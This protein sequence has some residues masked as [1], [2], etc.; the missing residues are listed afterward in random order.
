MRELADH[1]SAFLYGNLTLPEILGAWRARRP[2]HLRSVRAMAQRIKRVNASYIAD[3]LYDRKRFTLAHVD[4]MAELF[5]VAGDPDAVLWL[6]GVARLGEDR[7][8]AERLRV[9]QTLRGLAAKNGVY[10]PE[11]ESA[12]MSAGWPVHA[13]Y[14]LGVLP[15]FRPVPAWVSRAL[16]GRVS[17][18]EA[19]EALR[20]LRRLEMLSETGQR[21]D[22]S[23]ATWRL[24]SEA[25]TSAALYQTH[26]QLLGLADAEL[27]MLGPE[28]DYTLWMLALPAALWRRLVEILEGFRD[29]V[30]AALQDSDARGG[31]DRVLLQLAHCVPVLDLPSRGPLRA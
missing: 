26:D 2:A 23:P 20:I 15:G 30:I 3:L 27:D 31:A 28:H 1:P 29:D 16:R 13:T 12:M 8:H 6:E 4:L 19:D 18:E 11:L 17:L 22:Q 25:I 10:L 14:A 7:P 21:T 24:K 5:G 9:L